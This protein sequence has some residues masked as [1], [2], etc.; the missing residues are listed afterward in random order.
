MI[1]ASGAAGAGH[2]GALPRGA[3]AR[4]LPR[5]RTPRSHDPKGLAPSGAR[6]RPPACHPSFPGLGDAR[7][8]AGLLPAATKEDRYTTDTIVRATAEIALGRLDPSPANV[9]RTG[10]GQGVEALAVSIAAH[11]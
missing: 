2:H 10:A 9:R 5:G 1:V 6:P 4:G 11:G 8:A 3:S 7:E